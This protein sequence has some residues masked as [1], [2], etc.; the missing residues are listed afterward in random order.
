MKGGFIV[1]GQVINWLT[2][3]KS[4]SNF[5]QQKCQIFDGDSFSNMI[6]CLLCNVVKQLASKTAPFSV[7]G[8]FIVQMMT[9]LIVRIICSLVINENEN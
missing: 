9:G 2:E 3:S 6:F 7:S 8:R 1:E 5:D 4:E